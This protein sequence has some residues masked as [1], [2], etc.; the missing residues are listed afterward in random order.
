MIIAIINY[1]LAITFSIFAVYYI[2][3]SFKDMLNMP[4]IL[5]SFGI[6]QIGLLLIVDLAVAFISSAIPV[7]N[8]SRKRPIDA[9]RDR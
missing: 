8:T 5:L 4:V 9:I 7:I 1:I 2:N 3:I 6:R